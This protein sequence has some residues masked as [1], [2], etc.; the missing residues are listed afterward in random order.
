M[1]TGLVSCVALAL[2]VPVCLQAGVGAVVTT[3]GALQNVCPSR[4]RDAEGTRPQGVGVSLPAC[5]DGLHDGL[6]AAGT[7]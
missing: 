1:E 3:P 5:P 6:L 4:C 7:F 2:M